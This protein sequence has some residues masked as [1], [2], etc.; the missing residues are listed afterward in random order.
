MVVIIFPSRVDVGQVFLDSSVCNLDDLKLGYI[1]AA[2]SEVD[3][4]RP[5]CS[6]KLQRFE[7]IQ[8]TF[9]KL[10]CKVSC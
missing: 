9:K 10:Q 3:Q 7:V 6:E 2:Q 4:L 8:E 5:N 1:I